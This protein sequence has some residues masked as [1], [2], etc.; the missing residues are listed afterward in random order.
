MAT[1]RVDTAAARAFQSPSIMG[2]LSTRTTADFTRHVNLITM[3]C[4]SMNANTRAPILMTKSLV[5]KPIL[6]SRDGKR[7]AGGPPFGAHP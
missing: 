3:K 1:P 7:G 6:R 2:P 5:C 4:R